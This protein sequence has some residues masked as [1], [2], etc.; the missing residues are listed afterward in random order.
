MSDYCYEKVIFLSCHRRSICTI[1]NNLLVCDLP[2]TAALSSIS[3][4]Y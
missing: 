1:V 4:N 3:L 2:F